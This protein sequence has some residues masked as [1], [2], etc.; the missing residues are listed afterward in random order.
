MLKVGDCAPDFTLTAH[1]GTPFAL[2]ALRGRKLLLWFF[3]E[4]D[5]PGCALE[6]RGLR[7]HQEY[8]DQNNIAVAGVSFNTVEENRAFADKYSFRFPILSD[9]ARATALEYGACEGPRAAHAD[10]I[11]FLI[12]EQGRIARI[13]DQ[14]D[15]RDHAAKVLADVLGV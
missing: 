1:D 11:S 5:T 7:D 8:F 15:P 4:A 12:D 10:R 14:V 3:P 13:Y 9:G 6:G 2:A